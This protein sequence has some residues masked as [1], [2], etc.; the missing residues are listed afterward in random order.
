MISKFKQLTFPHFIGFLL[1]L[2]GWYVSLI[3]VGLDRF[4]ATSIHSKGSFIGLLII[5][6]GAYFPEAWN[7]LTKKNG[8]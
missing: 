8:D 2:V 7:A 5:L 1:I 3:N 6:I 4:T